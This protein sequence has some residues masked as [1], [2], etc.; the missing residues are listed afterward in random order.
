MIEYYHPDSDKSVKIEK[1]SVPG[2]VS[3]VIET[4]GNT[5]QSL[6]LREQDVEQFVQSLVN[7]GWLERQI[8]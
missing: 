5:Q 7:N 2:G 1:S 4:S 6:N 8:L 3:T